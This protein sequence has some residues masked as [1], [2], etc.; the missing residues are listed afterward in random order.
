[1]TLPHPNATG[2]AASFFVESKAT[3]GNCP[4]APTPSLGSPSGSCSFEILE[5][6]AN[7]SVLSCNVDSSTLNR[8]YANISSVNSNVYSN[9]KQCIVDNYCLKTSVNEPFFRGPKSL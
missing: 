5:I 3:L 7:G 6:D 4:A 8:Y 9:P 1:M 2:S